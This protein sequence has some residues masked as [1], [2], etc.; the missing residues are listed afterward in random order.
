MYGPFCAIAEAIRG[1]IEKQC[2][3][4]RD[5]GSTKWMDYHSNSPLSQNT[6]AAKLRPDALFALQAIAHQTLLKES[7]VRALF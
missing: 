6:Q 7:Q 1:F 3:S 2:L 5:M 4:V